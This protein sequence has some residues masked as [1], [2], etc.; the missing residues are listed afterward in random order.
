MSSDSA[1][2]LSEPCAQRRHLRVAGDPHVELGV[3]AEP[4]QREV[5]R[6]HHRRAR[7]GVVVVPA[8]VR[9][10][11]QRAAPVGP[12]L[13][14][15]RGH[16]LAQQR[17]R[18]FRLGC[19][20]QQRHRARDPVDG[21]LGDG[22]ALPPLHQLVG[23]QPRPQRRRLLQVRGHRLEHLAV[24]AAH[25]N[26]HLLQPRQLAADGPEARHEEVPHRDVGTGGAVQHL[27]QAGQ[28]IG[29]GGGVGECS[30]ASGSGSMVRP[31]DTAR[32]IQARRFP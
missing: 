19:L 26:A 25:Q 28:Q 32:R 2:S 7:L 5:R 8:E 16:H 1:Q 18:P 13:R 4:G 20:R 24:G 22:R 31:T 23:V 6:P 14:P 3:A 27:P 11:V 21:V 12:H 29:V 15:A 17:H 30:W 9:L 10:G